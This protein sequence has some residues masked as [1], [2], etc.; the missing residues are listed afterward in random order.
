VNGNSELYRVSFENKK[1]SKIMNLNMSRI[2]AFE[3]NYLRDMLLVLD[4][5]WLLLCDLTN[6][7]KIKSV[8]AT[9]NET[10]TNACFGCDNRFII[11]ATKVK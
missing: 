4:Y 8:K 9:Y 11:L 6:P 5:K 3:R 1:S 7:S 10:F 2:L